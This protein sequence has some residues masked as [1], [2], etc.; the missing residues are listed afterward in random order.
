MK[1]SCLPK[2]WRQTQQYARLAP[3]SVSAVAY[4][5]KGG[6]IIDGRHKASPLGSQNLSLSLA[7]NDSM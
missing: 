7:A 1:L 6:G 2:H 3:I 5:S 4:V